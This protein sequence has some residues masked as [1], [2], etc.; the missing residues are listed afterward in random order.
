M[1]AAPSD[2]A[3]WVTIETPLSPARLAVFVG[4]LERLFRINSLLEIDRWEVT[5]GDRIAFEARNLSN[6]K[7]LQSEL[8]VEQIGNGLRI[9]YS[10]LLKT[11]TSFQ[12][13]PS[14]TEGSTLIVTDDYSGS[15]ESERSQRLEEVDRS[16]H[17][18]G[19]DLHSYLQWWHRWSWL[20]PWRWY[21]QRVWQPM[22]PS[23]RRITR[24]ILWIGF[25]EMAL[26]LLLIAILAIEQ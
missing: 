9:N 19:Q 20:P 18:W 6:D 13:E 4:D 8:S 11:S 7:H 14:A 10:G 3:A 16:L 26:V 23:A 25:G 1:R 21:M 17:Q 24:L 5:A 2:D 12:V 22:K 15:D